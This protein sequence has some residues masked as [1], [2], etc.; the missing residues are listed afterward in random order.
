MR[1]AFD[2]YIDFLDYIN[3]KMGAIQASAGILSA[4]VYQWGKDQDYDPYPFKYHGERYLDNIEWMAR[5]AQEAFEKFLKDLPDS[6]GTA[7][8]P[9]EALDTRL[10]R[11][12][13][14]ARKE[15]L[16][17][18]EDSL[19]E[20]DDIMARVFIPVAR[21]KTEFESIKDRILKAEKVD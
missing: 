17:H 11:L 9:I 5:K 18:V 19:K 2:S 20:I 16:L 21:M 13:N 15:D 3:E 10:L 8:I 1:Q 12:R 14:N 7:V 4:L 6:R